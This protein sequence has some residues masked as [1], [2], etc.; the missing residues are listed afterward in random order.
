MPQPVANR[1]AKSGG[2][3]TCPPGPADREETGDEENACPQSTA[4]VLVHRL[5]QVWR[6]DPLKGGGASRASALAEVNRLATPS[7]TCF[8]RNHDKEARVPRQ[9]FR[10]LSA[11]AAV[12]M[13]PFV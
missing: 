3:P 5:L 2:C 6:A 4:S 13:A 12:R 8:H 9:D 11:R 1:C 10:S 7:P